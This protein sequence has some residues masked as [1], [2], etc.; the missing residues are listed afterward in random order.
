MSR[1]IVYLSI[2]GLKYIEGYLKHFVLIVD[3]LDYSRSRCWLHFNKNCIKSECQIEQYRL[4]DTDLAAPS[5][6]EMHDYEARW[7]GVYE[8]LQS[9]SFKLYT[10][11]SSVFHVEA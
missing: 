6:N 4:L 11:I 8:D 9:D 3:S 2:R 7:T 5:G 1:Y 10:I